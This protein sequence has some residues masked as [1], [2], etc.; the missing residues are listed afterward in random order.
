VEVPATPIK[1]P[2]SSTIAYSVQSQQILPGAD[3][4]DAL[5][6]PEKVDFPTQRSGA[7]LPTFSV[8]FGH[9]G[10]PQPPSQMFPARLSPVPTVETLNNGQPV[11]YSVNPYATGSSDFWGNGVTTTRSTSVRS[12]SSVETSTQGTNRET[13]ATTLEADV[14]RYSLKDT[15]LLQSAFRHEL[16]QWEEVRRSQLSGWEDLDVRP[17]SQIQPQIQPDRASVY[18]SG[19]TGTGQF[20]VLRDGRWQRV[21]A[22]ELY[23]T[24]GISGVMHTSRFSGASWAPG[25]V[26]GRP[27]S[28]VPTPPVPAYRPQNAQPPPITRGF[29]G[30]PGKNVKPYTTGSGRVTQQSSPKTTGVL[31]GAAVPSR[32]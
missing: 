6:D 11:E 21:D 4:T 32:W 7:E 25:D 20:E 31:G 16:P 13:A 27:P 24:S 1:H 12:K 26:A 8:A 10:N 22:R 30:L 5:P 17:Q 2:N 29:V 15:N 3:F 19:T 18:S 14:P 9:D 28:D 23:R